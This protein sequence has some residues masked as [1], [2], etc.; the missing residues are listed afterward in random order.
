MRGGETWRGGGGETR[1]WLNREEKEKSIP[2]KCIKKRERRKN[3][4]SEKERKIEE[5]LFQFEFS[6]P[7][8][9][10][11]IKRGKRI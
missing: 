8:L 9:T 5:N 11:K 1:V 4:I 7:K 6:S 2:W 3:V 10:Y